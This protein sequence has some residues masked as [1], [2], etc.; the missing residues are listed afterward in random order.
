M[1]EIWV[2][3]PKGG[4]TYAQ[5]VQYNKF[6]EGVLE[7]LGFNESNNKSNRFDDKKMKIDKF[8]LKKIV[9]GSVRGD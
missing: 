6:V 3:S 5:E 2:P 9:L 1:N 8:K 7:K 4:W